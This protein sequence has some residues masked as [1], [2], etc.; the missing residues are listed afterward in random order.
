MRACSLRPGAQWRDLRGEGRPQA[1]L[2]VAVAESPHVEIGDGDEAAEP[3]SAPHEVGGIRRQLELSEGELENVPSWRST[4]PIAEAVA[5][6]A[7]PVPDGAA[8][9][10]A[11]R[12]RVSPRL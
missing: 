9:C 2:P 3:E 10:R 8:G 5:A 7:L 4:S 6:A 11:A 12:P 1:R